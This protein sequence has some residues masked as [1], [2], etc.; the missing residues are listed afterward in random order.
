MTAGSEILWFVYVPV[1][2][3][4][5]G[6]VTG[7][8]GTVWLGGATVTTVVDAGA[9]EVVEGCDDWVEGI[10]EFTGVGVDNVF[11]I[12]EFLGVADLA[13]NLF[14]GV[15]LDDGTTSASSAGICATFWRNSFS[16]T[17]AIK[18]ISWNK[19]SNNLNWTTL[20]PI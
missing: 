7:A 13:P 5:T 8:D 11:P 14:L 4:A 18:T 3:A 9:T 16:N 15:F 20:K 19:R 12:T 1:V 2:S 10:W 6:V 17:C